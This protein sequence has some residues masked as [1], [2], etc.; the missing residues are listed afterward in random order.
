MWKIQTRIAEKSP[1]N[2][3]VIGACFRISQNVVCS[4]CGLQAFDQ[5]ATAANFE[6]LRSY[7][8]FK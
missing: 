3:C 1:W 2:V 6:A 8:A 5:F 4:T 7:D